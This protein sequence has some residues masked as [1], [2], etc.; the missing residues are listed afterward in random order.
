MTEPKERAAV[1]G[2]TNGGTEPVLQVVDVSKRYLPRAGFLS[3]VRQGPLTAVDGVTLELARG[4][5]LG[6][7]GES[8]CG[9]STLAKL[10]V[11]IEEP[12]SGHIKVLGRELN[13]LGRSELRR[14][15][16]DIQLV[17]QD[18]YT[19]LD[20]R[21]PVADLVAE[22]FAVHPDVLPRHRR[23]QRV[24]ELLDM[25]GLAGAHALRL[26]HQLSGGQRQ[27]V[28]IARA[29]ALD[30][31][32]LVLDEP[33]SAL[34]MSV[35]AQ[36]VNLLMD[37]Q[38]ELDLAYVFI[39]HDIGVV[40][41]LADEIAVMYLGRIVE[42]GPQGAVF[43]HAAHPFSNALLSAVPEPDPARRPEYGQRLL[44]G[45]TPSPYALPS[46]CRFRTRCWRNTDICAAQEPEL[47]GVAQAVI[48]GHAEHRVAC[49]HPG[50]EV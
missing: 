36:I 3:P 18:P 22:P 32:I 11:A 43:G 7:V 48:A 27:R 29:L 35:Q 1:P 8:G 31:K 50:T 14:A 39:A 26:P 40:A 34:D 12:T 47:T 41:H 6:L 30:P 37:L 5:T 25:V 42:Q 20:P 46:G 17:F 49:H 38:A 45:D 10:L 44:T 16:R 28:G 9:K 19:S 33:V 13:T 15:R 24:A 2:P 23:R 21:L 4:R